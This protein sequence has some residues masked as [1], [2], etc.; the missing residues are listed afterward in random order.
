MNVHKTTPR[1]SGQI[2]CSPRQ[3]ILIGL[4]AFFRLN[5]YNQCDPDREQWII[6]MNGEFHWSHSNMTS[7]E[8]SVVFDAYGRFHYAGSGP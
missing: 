7:N 5:E 8:I 2:P 3:T 6:D 1:Q 4:A